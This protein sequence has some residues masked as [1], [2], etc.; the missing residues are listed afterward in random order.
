MPK[1][2]SKPQ[3]PRHTRKHL[4]TDTWFLEIGALILAIC[5]FIVI[6]VLLLHYNGHPQFQWHGV[7]LNA[8]VSVL[9]TVARIGIVLPVAESLAQWKWMHFSKRPEPL[10]D[11]DLLDDASKGS[12]GSL[13][14]LWEKRS[15]CVDISQHI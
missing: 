5:A 10:E 6:L 1:T 12:R 7:T 4:L 11:F 9:A 3:R 15:L 2:Q 14:L 13:L 8:V